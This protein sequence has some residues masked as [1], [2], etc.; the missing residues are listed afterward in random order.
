MS[1]MPASGPLEALIPGTKA[2]RG[3]YK[4]TIGVCLVTG[5]YFVFMR[6]TTNK[7]HLFEKAISL[8]H[9]TV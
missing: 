6:L 8:C 9:I 1:K 5:G 7:Y 4:Q 2:H 3:V